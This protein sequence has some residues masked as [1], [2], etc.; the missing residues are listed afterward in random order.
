MEN[1]HH[2]GENL[3]IGLL[4]EAKVI[5]NQLDGKQHLD[6]LMVIA[7]A[8]EKIGDRDQLLKIL[9]L[10]LERLGLIENYEHQIEILLQIES[11]YSDYYRSL[12]IIEQIKEYLPFVSLESSQTEILRQVARVYVNIGK[13][14]QAQLILLKLVRDFW[15]RRRSWVNLTE[16]FAFTRFNEYRFNEDWFL[17]KSLKYS[18]HRTLYLEDCV[19]LLISVGMSYAKL[20]SHDIAME[21]HWMIRDHY[22]H[23]DDEYMSGNFDYYPSLAPELVAYYIH[24]EEKHTYKAHDVIDEYIDSPKIEEICIIAINCYIKEQDFEAAWKV[25]EFLDGEE[26]CCEADR[27]EAFVRIA[28][29]YLIANKPERVLYLLEKATTFANTID[30][31]EKIKYGILGDISRVYSRYE[32]SY[33]HNPIVLKAFS[34]VYENKYDK[35]LNLIESL[36][37]D[38]S[39]TAR[40]D[41]L[42]YISGHIVHYNRKGY[43]EKEV[44]AIEHKIKLVVIILQRIVNLGLIQGTSYPYLNTY[45]GEFQRTAE[46]YF[47]SS[48]KSEN[49]RQVL[50]DIQEIFYKITEGI[51]QGKLTY[52]GR[53]SNLS[54]RGYKYLIKCLSENYIAVKN[55]QEALLMKE[56]IIDD[57]TRVEFLAELAVKISQAS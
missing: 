39:L 56:E 47:I 42:T 43:K 10:A 31:S 22:E 18:E 27:G 26:T 35:A 8:Y 30:Y 14:K 3:A 48:Q 38:V 16:D 25:V 1:Q 9:D 21:I 50:Q 52:S 7:N 57:F 45:L 40:R 55:Y 5:A 33:N 23:S 37:K 53:G 6:A 41:L 2:K 13:H 20:G 49:K 19:D 17:W 44:E 15:D 51:R 28:E 11:L 36:D 32:I 12:E 34:L 54:E 24:S 46:S 29:S 4:E